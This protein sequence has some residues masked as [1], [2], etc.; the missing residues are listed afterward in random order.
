MKEFPPETV[1]LAVNLVDRFLQLREVKRTKLQLVGIS[2]ILLAARW[3]GPLIITIREAAWLTDN[4]YKYEQVVRMMG[5]VLA[6]F[7][8]DLRVCLCWQLA[9]YADLHMC[10]Q[11]AGTVY[12]GYDICMNLNKCLVAL[13][14]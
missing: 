5:E 2:A 13:V 10:V 11:C 4:T 6:V 12:E 3:M 8:G 14:Y 7:R 9:G 1:H